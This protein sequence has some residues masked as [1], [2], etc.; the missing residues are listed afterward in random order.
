MH[1]N[2]Q[3]VGTHTYT[4]MVIEFQNTTINGLNSKAGN[5]MDVMNNIIIILKGINHFNT[6]HRLAHRYEN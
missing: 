5:C 3:L 1:L 2:Y 6:L 4:F